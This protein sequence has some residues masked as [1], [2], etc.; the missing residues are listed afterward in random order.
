MRIVPSHCFLS[1]CSKLCSLFSRAKK[2][3]AW[4]QA[5]LT[6]GKQE[7]RVHLTDKFITYLVRATKLHLLARLLGFMLGNKG[8]IAPIIGTFLP[9]QGMCVLGATCGNKL[10]LNEVY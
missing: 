9:M 1:D 3:R 5:L 2:E 4:G 6:G 10:A 7:V 8:G